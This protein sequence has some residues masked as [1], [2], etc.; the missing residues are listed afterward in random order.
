M[1]R[2]AGVTIIAILGLVLAALAVLEAAVIL[3]RRGTFAVPASFA[4][5]GIAGWGLLAGAALVIVTCVGLLKLREW[6]RLL[7]IGLNAAHLLVAALGLMDALR[8]LHRPFFVGVMLR[9][10]V[11]LAIGVW[12]IAYLL[13]PKVKRAF[14][15]KASTAG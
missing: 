5:G 14:A 2:P 3:V 10:V 1:E 4:G 6:A 15:A 12:I 9:H 7:A 13:K 8:H 11:M